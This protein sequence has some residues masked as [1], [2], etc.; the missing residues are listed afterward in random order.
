MTSEI[1]AEA[2]VAVDERMIRDLA[3]VAGGLVCSV[4]LCAR[5]ACAAI[6][7][8]MTNAD[9]THFVVAGEPVNGAAVP[10][11]DHLR[12]SERQA[13]LVVRAIADCWSQVRAGDAATA[14]A[15][16][17]DPST[18]PVLI[19]VAEADRPGRLADLDAVLLSSVT[20]RL[21]HRLHPASRLISGGVH[22]AGIAL[23]AAAMLLADG[24]AAVLLVGVDTRLT[25][26]TIQADYVARRLRSENCPHGATPGEAAAAVLLRDAHGLVGGRPWLAIT[27]LGTATESA[28]PGADVPQRGDGLF[29]AVRAALGQAERRMSDVGWRLDDATGD[30]FVQR[31][32]VLG[33]QRLT[34]RT[35]MDMVA[36]HPARSLGAIGAAMLPA[37]LVVAA[38]AV[39][40][41]YAPSG[42]AVVHL[43]GDSAERLALVLATQELAVPER[44][45]P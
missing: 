4:G 42:I 43:G 17:V 21:G 23:R 11:A 14:F 41:R 25:G 38:H 10:L 22:G 19:L 45:G 8:D 1:I 24:A 20:T 31:D 30:P 26:G 27:G 34:R 36:W 39:S 12:G 32:T 3:I 37:L 7:C 13:E 9:V 6:R 5:H 44:A 18:I 29:T 35:A 28:V 40:Q 2:A 33:M 15:R 16:Q